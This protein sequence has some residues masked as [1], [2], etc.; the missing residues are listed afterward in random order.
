VSDVGDVAAALR[1]TILEG[2][3]VQKGLGGTLLV[4]EVEP[5][6]LLPAWRA[7]C[8]AMPVTGR[9]PVFTVP[10]GL[11]HEPEP[12]ELAELELAA[13]TLDPWAVYRRHRGDEPQ[14]VSDIE[15]YVEA[16]LGSAEVPRALEQLTGPV[17]EKDVQRW[18][19]DTLL[20]D[21]PLADRAFSGSEYLVGTSRWQ[22]W[23]EV[24]LVLLP[25][26]SPWLAPAWL[27][28]HGAT[29]PDGPAAWAAAML[30]WHQRWGAALVA[31]WGT[32]LQFV[33]E[34]RPRPGRQ[35]WE[36]AGQLMALGGNL[37]CE[38]WQLAI[39]LTRSD[40]WFLHD[41]P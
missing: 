25:T 28:Y 26:V 38:Q 36:L 1:G 7:A 2:H 34:R 20:A 9:W 39:A 16:F 8:S 30:R 29:R 13:R 27:T 24:Q 4:D 37:E 6:Q 33:A 14:D 41:R 32:V 31:G 3:P 17:T 23:P 18:T 22:T 10:G 40:E 12:D 21:P 15:D 11:Y 35:A 5:A 19:Y